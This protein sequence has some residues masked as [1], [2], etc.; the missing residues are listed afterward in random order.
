MNNTYM[1]I[2]ISFL[3]IVMAI[4]YRYEEAKYKTKIKIKPGMEYKIREKKYKVPKLRMVGDGFLLR[5]D[6]MIKI[7]RLYLMSY[8]FFKKKNILTWVSGGTLLGFIRHKTFMPWDDD[9]DMHTFIENKSYMFSQQFKQDLEKVGLQCLIMEGLTEE[10]SHYK[11]GIRIRMKDFKNPVMDIFFVEKTE[12][13]VKKIENWNTEGNEYN[14]KEIWKKDILLPIKGEFIDGM[15]V[16]IPNQPEKMLSLQYG[17][18]W[19]KVMYCSHPPHTLA[20]DLLDFIW[21]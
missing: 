6:F 8:L 14:L 9:I 10:K 17:E 4:V 7:R 3:L 19:D 11:G 12:E 18:D 1:I 21:H 20:F 13:E 15:T 2:L 5:E 16:N